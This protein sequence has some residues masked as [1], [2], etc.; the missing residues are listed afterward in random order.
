M[1][2]LKSVHDLK[3]QTRQIERN[4][5]P[6]AD[7]LAAAQAKMASLN[8]VL[9]NQTQAANTAAA[10]VAGLANG[11]AI[12]RTVTITSMSQ[13]GL[14]N[15]DLLI[16]FELTVLPDGLPPYPATTQQTVSQIRIAQIRPGQTLQA[17]IDPANPA[18][19]W[20]DLSSVGVGT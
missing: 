11:T 7:R 12:H 10:A 17:V 18:A 20:L 5:P 4:S 16:E 6:V 2:F 9:A 1:G 19:I 14:I 13:I 8:Q 15:F 3:Q